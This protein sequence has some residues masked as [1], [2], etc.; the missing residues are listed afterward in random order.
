MGGKSDAKDE[1][2]APAGRNVY[3]NTVLQGRVT[4]K[5]LVTLDDNTYIVY[6]HATNSNNAE[7]TTGSLFGYGNYVI[8]DTDKSIVPDETKPEE[9]YDIFSGEPGIG[10]MYANNNGSHM[11]FDLQTGA[12]FSQWLATSFNTPTP[13]FHVTETGFTVK[14]GALRTVIEPWGLYIP[15]ADSEEQAPETPTAESDKVELET[16]QEGKPFVLELRADGTMVTGWTNYEQTMLEGKW[17]VTYGV[18]V[19]EMDY[20]ATVAENAEVGLDVTV[21]YGQLAKRSTP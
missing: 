10:Y 11:Q 18:L 12:G 3:T 5:T 21:N 4:Y 2:P 16:S 1:L 14:L 15:A 7:Q 8:K 6:S 19:L 9:T 17:T 20:P 13:T